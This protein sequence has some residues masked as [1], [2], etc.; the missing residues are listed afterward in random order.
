MRIYT[1]HTKVLGVAKH[2][3][4]ALADMLKEA[5]H[6]GKAERKMSDTEYLAIEV[7]DVYDQPV[8]ERQVSR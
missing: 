5:E 1:R 3:L 2:E 8:R 4:S 7:N 6:T